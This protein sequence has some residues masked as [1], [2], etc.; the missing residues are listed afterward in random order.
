MYLV[1]INS[2]Y[3][4][5]DKPTSWNLYLTTEL[6]IVKQH[7]DSNGIAFTFPEMKKITAVSAEYNVVTE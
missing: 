2:I 5:N 6:A 7:L 3:S 1:G 4:N